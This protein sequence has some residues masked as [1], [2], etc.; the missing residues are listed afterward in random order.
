MKFT[1][2][3]ATYTVAGIGIV[4]ILFGILQGVLKFEIDKNIIDKAVSFLFIL[5]AVL[6]V[7]SKQKRKKES[8]QK[9]EINK[10][11]TKIDKDEPH[12]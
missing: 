4:L 1:S 5:A 11:E 7:Y 10:E 12:T 6:Y 9:E 8:E 3:Q 2:K